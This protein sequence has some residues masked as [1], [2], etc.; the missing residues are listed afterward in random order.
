[1]KSDYKQRQFILPLLESLEEAG[2]VNETKALYDAVAQ[3][4]RIDEEARRSLDP[5]LVVRHGDERYY[6]E[7]WDEPKFEAKLLKRDG[8]A[9][10]I[11]N[12]DQSDAALADLRRSTWR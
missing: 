9:V 3:R 5:F 6:V 11:T 12:K 10:K 4:T 1:M 2:G 8:G 7:V